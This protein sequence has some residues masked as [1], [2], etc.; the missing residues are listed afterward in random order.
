MGFEPEPKWEK[1]TSSIFL[2]KAN[3][4]EQIYWH[5]FSSYFPPTFEFENS[6]SARKRL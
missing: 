5:T 1:M 2:L 4:F 3:L 6:D